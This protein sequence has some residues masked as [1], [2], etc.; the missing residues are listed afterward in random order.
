MKILVY[1]AGNIGSLYAGLLKES[2]Q[3]VSILAR[4]KRSA[5][6]R[7]HGIQLENVVT[8]KETTVRVQAVG[9]LDRGVP[10]SPQVAKSSPRKRGPPSPRHHHP[11]S[12]VIPAQAGTS[13]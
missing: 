9:R 1:G 2:G 8:G 3:D 13:L 7:E 5:D 12:T 11:I 6:I 10:S 4:E